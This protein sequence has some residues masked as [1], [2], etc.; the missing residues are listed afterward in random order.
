MWGKKTQ[1]WRCY[2][3]HQYYLLTSR[4]LNVLKGW[5]QHFLLIHSLLLSGRTP[6]YQNKNWNPLIFSTMKSEVNLISMVVFVQALD[7]QRR[8]YLLDF[9][10]QKPVNKSEE[11]S[12]KVETLNVFCTNKQIK[13]RQEI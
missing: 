8:K 1:Y 4:L 10:E 7:L 3:Q 2:F 6:E 11:K 12:M 5:I 13:R 9:V